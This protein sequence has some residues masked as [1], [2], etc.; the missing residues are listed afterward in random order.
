M[1]ITPSREKQNKSTTYS[2]NSKLDCFLMFGGLGP[3]PVDPDSQWHVLHLA[4]LLRLRGHAEY[5]IAARGAVAPLKTR[6]A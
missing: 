3:A 6:A 5:S 2:D 1:P 4:S